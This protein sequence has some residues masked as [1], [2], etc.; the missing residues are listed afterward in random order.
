MNIPF[1]KTYLTGNEQKYL[2]AM[3]QSGKFSGNGEFT[4]KCQQ[5]LEQKYSLRKTLLTTSCTDALEMAAL[6]TRVGPGDEVILPSYT[7]VSTA[8][9][10]ALR[11]A[12]L[13]FCDSAADHPNID[14]SAIEQLIT[15]RTRVI[16]PVHYGGQACD[17][18]HIMALA[19]KYRLW[20]VEDAA[21]AVD[22]RLGNKYLGGIGHLGAF[23]FHETKNI[24]AGEGGALVINHADFL[25]RAEIHWEKGTNRSAF[26]RGEVDKYG[27]VDLGSSFL[28]SEL[29]S[30]FLLAQL[31]A[32]EHI[33]GMRMKAWKA[34]H[35]A[36]SP[37]EELG[38]LVMPD[39]PH[40][41]HL[42]YLVCRSLDERTALIDQ[43]KL[44]G[45]ASVFH[46]LSLHSSPYF[47]SKHDGRALP[48]SDRF[49]DCLVRLPM[50]AELGTDGAS[51]VAEEV[52]RFYKN[53]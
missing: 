52:L 18:A 20:V 29:I 19:E 13:V 46:Y 28:P 37:L 14:A 4:R 42:F 5:M 6:L 53:Q 8:N 44:K 11:G 12:T 7:F 25:K 26:F 45:I 23:S 35:A 51:R 36:L 16:V 1:N 41:A 22:A 38:V 43:L 47:A 30:A 27:W 31:E 49:T 33:Q 3:L 15:P 40:N 17:M 39:K 9:A 2:G 21:Q 50:Y 32:V 34:Y 24:I 48:H 10:F